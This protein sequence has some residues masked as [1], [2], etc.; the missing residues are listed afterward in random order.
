MQ[1]ETIRIASFKGT[2]S[3]FVWDFGTRLG[4]ST[5]LEQIQV[6]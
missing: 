4:H 1:P 6:L 3:V 5:H 2:S